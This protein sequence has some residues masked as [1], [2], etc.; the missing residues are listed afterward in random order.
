MYIPKNI[1]HTMDKTKSWKIIASIFLLMV[2]GILLKNINISNISYIVF[3]PV[4]LLSGMIFEKQ[5]IYRGWLI[6][7]IFAAL[8]SFIWYFF[9]PEK[10]LAAI[11]WISA[12]SFISLIVIVLLK[13]IRKVR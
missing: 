8:Y 3:V 2:I 13:H 1:N 5:N 7:T 9:N 12:G 11:T 6:S 10:A 4:I